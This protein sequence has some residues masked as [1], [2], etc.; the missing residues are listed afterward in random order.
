[1]IITVLILPKSPFCATLAEISPI[2][3]YFFFV[4]PN[5]PQLLIHSFPFQVLY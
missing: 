5:V 4:G 1:M 2:F 3:L